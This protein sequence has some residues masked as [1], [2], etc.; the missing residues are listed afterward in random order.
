MRFDSTFISH[1]MAATVAL[2]S[3]TLA[4]EGWH[5]DLTVALKEAKQEHKL[6]LVDFTGSDW[7][8]ACIKLRKT[9]LDAADFRQYAAE[10]FVFMEVDLPQRKSFDPKLRARNE[11]LAKQYHVA[12]YPSVLVLNPQGEVVGGFE[13]AITQ[14]EA[15]SALDNAR[16][17][18]GL[19][20]EASRQSGTA[21]ARTLMQVYR[22]FPASKTFAKANEQLKS[23]IMKADPNN[24][25]GIHD[26]AAAQEQARR[27][28]QQ[29]NAHHISSPAMGAL[30]Q[31]Q[32][33]EAYPSNRLVIL[34]ELCQH[35]LATAE[36]VE[37][38]Q[39]ARKM[40]E[41]LLPLLPEKEAADT[42]HFINTYFSD[43]AALLQMLKSNSPG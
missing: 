3:T 36:T 31:Q 22:Q 2:S 21:K 4:A 19:L 10:H 13:G 14:K 17:A 9:V 41:Q 26:H 8:S 16:V 15:I 39:A 43:P 28:L 23:E 27:F 29:R 37:D 5:T 38:I 25:T 12:G 1:C 34:Q 6:V 33:K 35:A 40:F 32:L 11:A 42:R 30:L 7:C 24:E 20:Q 18:A